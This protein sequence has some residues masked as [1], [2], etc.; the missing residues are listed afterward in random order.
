MKKFLEIIDKLFDNNLFKSVLII[1]IFIL[2]YKLIVKL[3]NKGQN[4][5]R[6]KKYSNKKNNT[7]IKVT[8]SILKYVF[9]ILASL[10]VL[11][12][13]GIDVSSLLAGVGIVSIIVGLA[14][15]DAL[16]DII[17]GFSIINENYFQVG[18]IVKYGNIEGKVI[19]LGIKT[20]KIM[21]IRS[22]NTISIANRNIE[23]IEVV[24]DLVDVF[25]PLPYELPVQRQQELCE[26]IASSILNN[27]NVNS[28]KY[29]EV[30]SLEDSYIKHYIA[31]HCNNLY[32][33]QVLRDANL[34]ILKTLESEGVS[35]PYNQLDVHNK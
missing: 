22:L 25:V 12:I 19:S 31:V 18:D 14:I 5:S 15:Q 6:Y 11:N 17:R 27:S 28:S 24:S 9:F 35:V 23:Q 3:I 10:I 2:F 26:K 34:T 13:N 20:T 4:S 30:S 7:L 16:K 33:T 21:D 29:L 8:T 32:K 1:L